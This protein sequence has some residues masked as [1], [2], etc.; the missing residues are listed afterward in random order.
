MLN[1]LLNDRPEVTPRKVGLAPFLNKFQPRLR[2]D[3]LTWDFIKA[4]R[5]YSDGSL[6]PKRGLDT[7]YKH[8]LDDLVMQLMTMINKNARQ[9]GRTIDF[10]EILYGYK[11]VNPLHG[12]DYIFDLL[13]IYRKHKGRRMTMPVRRHAYLQ[14]TFMDIEFREEFLP[15]LPQVAPSTLSGHFLLQLMPR[16]SQHF[17]NAGNKGAL[18]SSEP[19]HDVNII[20]NQTI[21]FIMPLAGRYQTFLAFMK[22]F[23]NACLRTQGQ[24]AL[25]VMLFHS[26]TDDRTEETMAYISELQTKYPHHDLRVIPVKGPFSRALALQQ[27]SALYERDAL[28]FFIDVD[29]YLNVESLYRIR[30]LIIQHRQ[31]YFPIVFSQYDPKMLCPS[32]EEKCILEG[33]NDPFSF[34]HDYGYWRQFGFGIAGIYKSDFEKIGGFDTTIMGWGKEDVDLF[35]RILSSNL[36]VYRAVDPG[37]VHIFHPINCDPSLE[38]AQY[39][40]CLGTK[41]A[42]Y[43]SITR[44]AALVRKTDEIINR[45]GRGVDEGAKEDRHAQED[46]QFMVA[47]A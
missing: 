36:T 21:H 19:I 33:S 8:A 17:Y 22:N 18:Q 12:A 4:R 15:V 45:D 14:Q 41:V 13:L 3:V 42:T 30:T 20:L 29:I 11:R 37:I 6:N 46:N 43:G 25:A 5:L 38:P 10:K 34:N 32:G 47:D 35:N 24:I 26:E 31:V 16:F 7:A 27:G 2:K 23:E 9:R 1:S 39:Q 44:L 40:M 28:M